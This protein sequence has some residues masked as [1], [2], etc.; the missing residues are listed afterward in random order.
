MVFFSFGGFLVS[1]LTIINVGLSVNQFT[2][3]FFEGGKV[4][5]VGSFGLD[6]IFLG[7]LLSLKLLGH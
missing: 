1:D 5:F 3:V 2:L 6:F 7:L 4:K